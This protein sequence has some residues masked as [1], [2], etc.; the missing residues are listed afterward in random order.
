MPVPPLKVSRLDATASPSVIPLVAL[1][2]RLPK[3]VIASKA[4]T[5][6]VVLLIVTLL[7]ANVLAIVAMRTALPRAGDAP[8]LM[9]VPVTFPPKMMI[10]VGMPPAEALLGWSPI[11]A[12]VIVP[13][14]AMFPEVKT[15]K[16][17]P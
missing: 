8:R 12:A 3:T 7:P 6:K 4:P 10:P 5:E 2:V 16:L 14:K 9:F 11:F 13:L 1:I 15:V 17:V